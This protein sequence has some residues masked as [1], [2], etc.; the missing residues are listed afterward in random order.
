[1]CYLASLSRQFF[2]GSLAASALPEKQTIKTKQTQKNPTTQKTNPVSKHDLLGIHTKTTRMRNDHH[3]AK[4]KSQSPFFNSKD[5][6]S[7][8]VHEQ[9]E[10]QSYEKP[11]KVS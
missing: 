8:S 2:N 10:N 6:G 1:M 9:W 11:I 3:S 5:C 4:S 7:I